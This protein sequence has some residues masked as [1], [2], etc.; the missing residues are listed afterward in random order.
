ML[1]LL[2]LAAVPRF[3]VASEVVRDCVGLMLDV[4]AQV[5][6]LLLCVFLLSHSHFFSQSCRIS[7][8]EFVDVLTHILSTASD[9]SSKAE[10]GTEIHI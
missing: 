7:S 1:A 4:G 3:D 9:D 10:V 5:V 2:R 6:A 8:E